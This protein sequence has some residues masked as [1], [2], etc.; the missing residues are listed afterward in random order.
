MFVGLR[1]QQEL[2]KFPEDQRY[3]ASRVM[4]GLTNLLRYRAGADL[5]EIS[6]DNYGSSIKIPGG[7]VGIPLGTI[8][9]TSFKKNSF[10][11]I[12]FWSR[13][14]RCFIATHEGTAGV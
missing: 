12:I 7:S 4:Y 2:Q 6:A 3:D 11:C 1:I 9:F 14:C 13:F 10:D 8:S 5:N